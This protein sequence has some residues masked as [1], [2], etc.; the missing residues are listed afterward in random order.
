M[1]KFTPPPHYLDPRA[2]GYTLV[3]KHLGHFKRLY[4]SIVFAMGQH[5]VKLRTIEFLIFYWA[6]QALSWL[7]SPAYLEGGV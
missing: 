2:K 3:V 4:S 5:P 1:T 7:H 6:V